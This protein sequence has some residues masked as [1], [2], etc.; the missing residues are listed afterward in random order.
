MAYCLSVYEYAAD[1]EEE[2][3]AAWRCD[4]GGCH[5][6]DGDADYADD[7]DR[8]QGLRVRRRPVE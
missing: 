7:D 3:G 2:E 1:G 4:D 8:L 5:E 6:V